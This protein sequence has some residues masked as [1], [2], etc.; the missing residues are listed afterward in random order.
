MLFKNNGDG[1]SILINLLR[2]C[3]EEFKLD[4]GSPF[5]V[6][7]LKLL[8][9]A[10]RCED[11]VAIKNELLSYGH[12]TAVSY[13]RQPIRLV[14]IFIRNVLVGD[15]KVRRFYCLV[16]VDSDDSSLLIGTDFVSACIIDKMNGSYGIRLSDLQQ[17]TMSLILSLGAAPR[18]YMRYTS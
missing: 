6:I 13:T 8:C 2:T 1:Y 7:S 3:V 18:T 11:T 5:T 9:K 12:I 15:E 17:F 10:V 14:P 16:N 4:T